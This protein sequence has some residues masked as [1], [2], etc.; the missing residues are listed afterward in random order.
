MK[1]R[2]FLA[3]AAGTT[4]AAAAS[5]F[6]APAISQNRIQWRMVTTWPK[7]F[8]GLGQSADRIAQRVGEMSDGR[9]TIRVFAGGELV[10]ALESFDAVQRGA[11]EC[12]HGAAY[13]WQGKSKALNFFTGVPYGMT[14]SEISAWVRYMGG[15][16]VWDEA[17][18]AFGLKG[19]MS[20]QTGV[21]AGGWF[22][23]EINTIEDVQGIKFRTPGLGG[24]VWKKLGVTTVNLAAGDIFQALQ[25][26]TLDAAEFVGPVTDFALG[27]HQV[28]KNYYWPS[29]NEPGLATEF[30]AKRD[31][32][33][34]L[35]KDM[36]RILEVVCAADYE[37]TS[38]FFNAR[39]ADAL[40]TMVTR[41]GVQVK[42]F[43]RD[44]LTAAGKAAGEVLT[45]LRDSG[46]PIT[47]KV[48]NSYVEARRKLLR[49]SSISDQAYY[50]ARL[51]PFT[52]VE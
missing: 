3:G 1:R 17:Y 4:A 28:A 15:Q 13:Y 49:W 25:S 9:F 36:Q 38:A 51:L 29:F 31:A 48:V 41:H 50:N 10:P 8:P 19:F 40:N 12:M 35:P 2:K 47:K 22:R 37:E 52:Y 21:Q 14:S 45:E 6:P 32:F 23:K 26:G 18:A 7:G 16:Q 42:A 27:F 44:L 5:T 34:Q 24:D 46:D 30:S 39:N 20:G 11:A 33:D 43:P